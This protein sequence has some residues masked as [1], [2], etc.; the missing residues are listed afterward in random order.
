ME[1]TMPKPQK[2]L[3]KIFR[4]HHDFK[5]DEIIIH[6]EQFNLLKQHIPF[7]NDIHLLKVYPLNL[8][9]CL[10]AN[11]NIPTQYQHDDYEFYLHAYMIDADANVYIYGH[12]EP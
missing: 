2:R 8:E 1:F 9:Q 4:K 10:N 11:I 6:H 3:I 5:I 12:H 7:G